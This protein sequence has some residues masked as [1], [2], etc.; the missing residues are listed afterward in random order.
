MHTFDHPSP[1][2][3]LRQPTPPTPFNAVPVGRR[4]DVYSRSS[5]FCTQMQCCYNSFNASRN[6]V[7]KS[8][9]QTENLRI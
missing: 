9:G 2:R 5:E 8:V 6:G 7:F 4:L 1:R 3:S